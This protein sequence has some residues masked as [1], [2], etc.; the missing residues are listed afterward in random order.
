MRSIRNSYLLMTLFIISST[1]MFGQQT[2][3]NPTRNGTKIGYPSSSFNSA[4]TTLE[5]SLTEFCSENG[6]VNGGITAHT[7]TG[8]SY[9]YFNGSTWVSG[10]T[11][12]VVY[13]TSYEYIEASETIW[14]QDFTTIY[15]D[16]G[17]VGIGLNVNAV[18]HEGQLFIGHDAVPLVFKETDQGNDIGSLWR[19][20][21]DAKILRFDVSTDGIDFFGAD[22]Y[23]TPLSL[24]LVDNSTHV[25][26]GT[27]NP[28]KTLD[29]NGDAYFRG[30]VGIGFPDPGEYKLAVNGTIK[31]KEVFVSTD[32]WEDRVF[33]EGY[34]A[35]SIEETEAFIKENGHLPGI[36]SEKEAIENG[37]GLLDMQKKL[38]RKMEEMTLQMIA[39]KK[40]NDTL[41]NEIENIKTGQQ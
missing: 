21:L 18:D 4:S 40:E 19:M 10:S 7:L 16:K 14:S 25:G 3:T 22:G 1:M 24:S 30:K 41:K 29:V 31:A 39:L 27:G 28:T 12:P 15:Y 20:P 33:K 37:V 26:I 17:K 5:N 8:G 36:P 9:T 13:I 11:F 38:L 23:K 6:W 2:G 35:P 32:G 34:D